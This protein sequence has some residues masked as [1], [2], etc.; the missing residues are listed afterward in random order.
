MGDKRPTV[1][2]SAE[3]C[4][5]I[6]EL[7]REGLTVR[8]ISSE[9]GASKSAV[10]D[11]IQHNPEAVPGLSPEALEFAG[12]LDEMAASA[13]LT[14]RSAIEQVARRVADG[15]ATTA[16]ASGLMSVA[17]RATKLARLLRGQGGG[18]RSSGSSANIQVNVGL[19][20]AEAAA[21]AALDARQKGAGGGG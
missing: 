19:T 8:A 14:G 4:A 3:V 12:D 7:R 6:L 11:L 21:L 1:K 18:G 20:P 2:L 13:L 17:E 16:D 10:H 15:A 5:R 9:T